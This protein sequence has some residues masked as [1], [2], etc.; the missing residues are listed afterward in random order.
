MKVNII[1]FKANSI[2][3]VNSAVRT[4]AIHEN[5]DKYDIVYIFV[6]TVY[7][8]VYRSYFNKK[9]NVYGE[10]IQLNK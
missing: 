1:Y 5:I 9:S 7:G 3:H 2:T 4:K 10:I 6:K 8:N